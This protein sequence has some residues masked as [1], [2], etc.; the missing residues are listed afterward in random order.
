MLITGN[1][2]GVNALIN[3]IVIPLKNIGFN[4][5]HNI[6]IMTEEEKAKFIQMKTEAWKG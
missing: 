6:V 4:L 1:R 3:S 5:D 2:I